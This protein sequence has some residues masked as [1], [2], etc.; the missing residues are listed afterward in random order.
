MSGD[1]M[2]TTST[3]PS[4]TLSVVMNTT[5][6]E[7]EKLLLQFEKDQKDLQAVFSKGEEVILWLVLG[8][9][10]IFGIIANIITFVFIQ[11]TP[12]LNRSV[13]N[14]FLMSLCVSDFVSAVNSPFVIYRATWG[15]YEWSIPHIFCK[16]AISLDFWT[17]CVTIQHILVFSIL[18]LISIKFPHRFGVLKAFHA[19]VI[20]IVIWMETMGASFVVYYIWPGVFPPG[21]RTPSGAISKACTAQPAW[22]GMLLGYVQIGFPIVLYVPMIA[23]VIVTAA[24]GYLIFQRKRNR[25][26]V[27]NLQSEKAATKKENFALIQLALIIASFMLGYLPDIAYRMTAIILRAFN[28]SLPARGEWQFS[29]TSHCLL[30]LSECLNPVFYNLGSSNMRKATFAFMKRI[31]PCMFDVSK[32]RMTTSGRAIPLDNN[33]GS[34]QTPKQTFT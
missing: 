33:T 32:Q 5:I 13:F 9:F 8:T 2:M 17:S 4:Y 16:L 25:N 31:V 20:V 19:K 24:L 26:K 21:K 6:N 30:R 28:Q 29:V 7:T 1:Y 3:S 22:I 23:V 11:I 34:S 14:I 10:A 18:R 27:S 15:F 12:K